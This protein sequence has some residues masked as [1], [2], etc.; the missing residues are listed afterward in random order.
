MIPASGHELIH[1]EAKSSCTE[2]GNIEYWK[3][4]KCGKYFSDAEG[5]TSIEYNDTVIP[6]SGHE[7]IKVEAK[8]STCTED[9]NT[10]YWKCNKCEK[11]FS[12]AEGITSIEYNDILIPATGHDF[13]NG[14]CTVCGEVD[15]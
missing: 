6:A 13:R 4:N 8:A 15:S 12:D 14:I 11:I 3:C 1:I 7:L 2:D 10:E 5:K 9:G